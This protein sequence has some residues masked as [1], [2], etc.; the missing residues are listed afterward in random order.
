MVVLDDDFVAR[1]IGTVPYR[2]IAAAGFTW[3][4]KQSTFPPPSQIVDN[5]PSLAPQGWVTRMRAETKAGEP[6]L[7]I[8]RLPTAE[9]DPRYDSPPVSPDE[10]GLQL[11]M[12]ESPRLAMAVEAC[13][14]MS[15]PRYKWQESYDLACAAL[16][17]DPNWWPAREEP[18]PL[19]ELSK[20]KA[21][22]FAAED[23]ETGSVRPDYGQ[24]FK[25]LVAVLVVAAI[26]GIV[27]VAR[28]QHR[29]VA[30]RLF[31]PW[32]ASPQAEH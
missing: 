25:L 12:A 3:I 6:C 23:R 21:S 4:V 10:P 14:L 22:D 24:M 8:L 28:D 29:D 5:G 13:R 31:A 11:A 30:N 15:G 26:A 19:M 17:L 16:G 18:V 2:V 7:T 32:P 1:H 20:S 27:G 9:D